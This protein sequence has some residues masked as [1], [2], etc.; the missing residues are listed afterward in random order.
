LLYIHIPFCD[1]KCFYCAFNSYTSKNYL[2]KD[3][4]KALKIQFE[5]EKK[6]NKFK[7]VFI[8]GGTPS[9]M[10]LDF[11]ERLFNLISPYIDENTEIT[12]EANP[13]STK[14]EWLKEL[15]KLGIN[16]ISFGVQSFNDEK[17]KFLGRNHSSKSALISIENAKK[18]LTM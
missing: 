4:F 17:L 9:V 3:Y 18:F 16:R 8:G 2:K 14:I 11:Y 7:S 5:K 10:N 15:K 1:S 6:P 13:N 12:I